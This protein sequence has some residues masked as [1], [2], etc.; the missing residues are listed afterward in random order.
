MPEFRARADREAKP[1]TVGDT[2]LTV[3]SRAVA[4][5]L[6]FGHV[7]WNRPT[8]VHVERGGLTQELRVIDPTRLVQLAIYATACA[9]LIATIA[10]RAAGVR[11]RKSGGLR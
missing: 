11:S 3:V 5:D 6:P 9:T 4:L 2:R 7:V 8:T 1:I 10:V